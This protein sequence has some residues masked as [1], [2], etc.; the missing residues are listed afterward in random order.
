[1]AGEKFCHPKVRSQLIQL[2]SGGKLLQF[3]FRNLDPDHQI[4]VVHG[5]QVCVG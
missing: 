2:S 4:S 5:F 3:W 1:M